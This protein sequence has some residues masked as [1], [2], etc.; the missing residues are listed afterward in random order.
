MLSLEVV[1]RPSC[2]FRL[3]SKDF[4]SSSLFSSSLALQH[5]SSAPAIAS[6]PDAGGVSLKQTYSSMSARAMLESL[7]AS[8]RRPSIEGS[9]DNGDGSRRKSSG[10]DPPGAVNIPVSPPLIRLF[11]Q[12]ELTPV[13]C[14]WLVVLS[15]FTVAPSTADSLSSAAVQ[16]TLGSTVN[17]YALLIIPLFINSRH[18][19]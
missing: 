17:H 3:E 19:C 7:G 10:S 9:G 13:S 6:V 16:V 15:L 11:C 8:Q 14:R 4:I 1:Y 5:P 18:P 2:Q 12:A